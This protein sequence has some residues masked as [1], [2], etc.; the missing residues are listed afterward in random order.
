MI[1]V[2]HAGGP[3]EAARRLGFL[4]VSRSGRETLLR[5]LRPCILC[6]TNEEL[7]VS[8]AELLVRLGVPSA[9]AGKKLLFSVSSAEQVEKWGESWPGEMETLAPVSKAI[10][11][12]QPKGFV[13][14]CGD[15]KLV[16]GGAPRIMGILN[17]TPDSFSDGGK[18][19]SV[20]AAVRRGI[21]MAAEGA[22]IIDV[23]GESTR[24][25]SFP[26]PEG[27]EIAR[28][29]PV[30]RELAG[31]T[32]ALLSVDTTKAGVA[33]EAV[34]A[35]ACII[36]DTS[37]L[38]DDPG[39]AVVARESGCAVV[40]MHRRGTPAT[41]QVEPSY[42]SLFD[43]LLDELSERVASAQNAGI[44]HERVIVDP[45]VGFGKRLRDNLALHRN[46]QDV[47]NLGRPVLFGP[48]RKSF[49]G[50]I[51]GKEAGDRLFGTVA[52]VA[53]AASGGG[54]DILRVHDVKETLDVV[55]VVAAIREGAEC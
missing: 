35:G 39:M 38:A 8:L 47:R 26:V 13:V 9:W 52:A 27:E 20:E 18:Y 32:G 10:R 7:A 29:V 40:L 31:E 1:R 50:K 5:E 17:V 6:V 44:P 37:A 25:G 55:R 22:D 53:I 42:E 48:S 15:R 34:A 2:L 54:A 51:T 16:L 19:L 33:R 24:P 30:I 46:L 43:E 12:F 21:E 45:G 11:R 23:G 14:P 49:L 3:E 41:M 4:G 28:V 36:N